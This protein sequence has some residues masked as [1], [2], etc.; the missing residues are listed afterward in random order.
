MYVSII[1]W[2]FEELCSN[3]GILVQSLLQADCSHKA[4][5]GTIYLLYVKE[6]FV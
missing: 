5:M 4:G 6:C 2:S 3:E 1:C